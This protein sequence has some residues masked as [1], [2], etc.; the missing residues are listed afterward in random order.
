M[1]NGDYLNFRGGM[2]NGLFSPPLL[3]H[4]GSQRQRG[5]GEEEV[6]RKKE[7]KERE[8]KSDRETEK[9]VGVLGGRGGLVSPSEA[10]RRCVGWRSPLSQQ[11]LPLTG[12]KPALVGVNSRS[13]SKWLQTG[14]RLTHGRCRV[15]LRVDVWKRKIDLRSLNRTGTLASICPGSAQGGNPS[16]TSWS[17]RIRL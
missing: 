15:P 9:S 17:P 7:A 2:S 8:R 11:V 5:L 16:T 12:F 13:S 3:D 10:Q 6:E 1:G 14:C 4:S